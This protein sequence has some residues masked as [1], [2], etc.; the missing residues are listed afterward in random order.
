MWIRHLYVR[1]IYCAA[2]IIIT[3][4]NKWMNEG[5]YIMQYVFYIVYIV[6]C[7][8]RGIKKNLVY[9]PTRWFYNTAKI[10]NDEGVNVI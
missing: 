10:P 3:N 2:C 8:W 9:R 1:F 4:D 7:I 5:Y 6:N